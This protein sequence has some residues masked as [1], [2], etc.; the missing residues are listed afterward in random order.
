MVRVTLYSDVLCIWAYIS[1]IRIDELDSQFGDEVDIC[2]RFMPVF[3]DVAGKMAAQWADRGGIEGYA[4]HVQEVASGFG[5]IRLHPEVWVGTTPSSS[6]PAHL[7]LCAVKTSSGMAAAQALL[8]VIRDAFFVKGR[9]VSHHDVLWQLAADVDIDMAAVQ[10]T[11]DDGTAYAAL[12]ADI[13][14]TRDRSIKASPTLEL[15]DGRQLLSGNVGYR[16]IEANIRELLDQP[17]NQQSWC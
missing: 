9:D 12:G 5:H 4:A 15:N 3:G 1:Q 6:L 7:L 13:A 14:A 10:H 16:V 11:L 2:Y 17:G 8:R